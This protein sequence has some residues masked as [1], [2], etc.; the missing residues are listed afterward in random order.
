MTNAHR[1]GFDFAQPDADY[2]LETLPTGLDTPS[3]KEYL[4]S[5]PQWSLLMNE[6]TISEGSI[7]SA[8]REC[9]DPEIPVNLVDLGLIY[10][11]KIIDD[12]VGVKMTLTSPG[13]G[14]SG[15]I[16][17]NVRNQVLKVPGV[18]DADVRIV[19]EPAWSPA[20]M[21]AEAKKKL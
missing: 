11:I 17:Q 3:G 19:W 4:R 8:L 9:Y 12:W 14:M 13:C 18:K 6:Q 21:S 16:S 5:E 10:D 2:E 1:A 15:M 7:L 20:R